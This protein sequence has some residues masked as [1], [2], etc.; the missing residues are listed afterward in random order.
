VNGFAGTVALA[1]S[2][3]PANTTCAMSPQ[4]LTLPSA[5]T[6]S[7]ATVTLPQGAAGGTFVISFTGSFG[8]VKREVKATLVKPATLAK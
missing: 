3:G 1:C 6:T 4:S 2:G 5:T 7:K 8:G